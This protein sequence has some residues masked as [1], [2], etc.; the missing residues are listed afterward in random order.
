MPQTLLLCCCP[1][2]PPYTAINGRV[3]G[4][5]QNHVD[6]F[7]R[8]GRCLRLIPSRG[9]KAPIPIGENTGRARCTEGKRLLRIE[10]GYIA[11]VMYLKGRLGCVEGRSCDWSVDSERA[12]MS[13][14][15]RPPT[16]VDCTSCS[17]EHHQNRT[18][19]VVERRSWRSIELLRVAV[20]KKV[21]IGRPC[22][23]KVP[24]KTGC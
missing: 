23:A 1:S 11:N 4:L 18:C 6:V 24:V 14:C 13:P 17:S 10:A 16:A 9:H 2:L 8:N 5:S 3:T 20:T 21:T 7:R 12:S 22:L 19:G 15:D